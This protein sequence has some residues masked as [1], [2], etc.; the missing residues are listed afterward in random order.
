MKPETIAFITFAAIAFLV[1]YIMAVELKT[2]RELSTSKASTPEELELEKTRLE[3]EDLRFGWKRTA[4]AAVGAVAVAVGGWCM[5]TAI[6]NQD[7]QQRYQ[8]QNTDSFFRYLDALGDDS[9]PTRRRDAVAYLT[10]SAPNLSF[11]PRPLIR[12]AFVYRVGVE[13]DLAVQ[14]SMRRYLLCPDNLK[15]P[16]DLRETVELE[17]DSNRRASYTF[18]RHQGTVVGARIALEFRGNRAAFEDFKKAFARG[19]E[20]RQPHREKLRSLGQNPAET[21]STNSCDTI[22][23]MAGQA[24]A[25]ILCAI[26]S[27]RDARRYGYTLGTFTGPPDAYVS[28]F[29]T[30]TNDLTQVYRRYLQYEVNESDTSELI[31]DSHDKDLD[32][33]AQAISLT[34]TL[35]VALLQKSG[36]EGLSGLD[37]HSTILPF[38]IGSIQLTCANLSHAV[39]LGDRRYASFPPCSRQHARTP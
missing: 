34:G 2:L 1:I 3:I 29:D 39:I 7:V 22:T 5:Q 11:D 24:A 19:E 38:T 10:S 26:E 6:A 9:N 17:L 27:V 4:A 31:F 36:K 28:F 25:S 12:K 15:S 18:A 37:L 13:D 21:E 30:R 16:E 14:M 23:A 33:A 32:S 20:L 35:V 8:A